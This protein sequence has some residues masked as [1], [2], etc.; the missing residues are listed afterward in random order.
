MV[1]TEK[2]LLNPYP[3]P[4]LTIIIGEGREVA[5]ATFSVVPLLMKISAF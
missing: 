5:A 2:K 3:L 4:C 1:G